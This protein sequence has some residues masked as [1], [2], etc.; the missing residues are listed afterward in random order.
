MTN[1]FDPILTTSTEAQAP[2]IGVMPASIFYEKRV[3][4]LDS[5][6]TRYINA[7]LHPPYEWL[8]EILLLVEI[9][10]SLPHSSCPPPPP[11]ESEGEG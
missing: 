8:L 6:L 7:G 9:L 4:D 11:A 2:P 1:D 10:P 3:F 5:A